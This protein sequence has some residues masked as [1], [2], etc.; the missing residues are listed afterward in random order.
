M[1]RFIYILVIIVLCS[2]CGML[3]H[4]PTNTIVQHDTTVVYKNNNVYQHDSIYVYKDKVIH[5]K[6]DTVYVTETLFKDRWKV[7]EVHDTTYIEKSKDNEE[8]TTITEY[9]EKELTWF[10][11]LFI[12]LGKI[13]SIALILFILYKILKSKLI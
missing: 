12:A 6:G 11:K 2:S 7:K 13:L 8:Q 3:K 10:Q 9:V 5:T 4:Q 1:K